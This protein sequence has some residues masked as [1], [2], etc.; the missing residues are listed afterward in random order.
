[1]DVGKRRHTK[2]WSMVIL[3]EE[4]APVVTE[5]TLRATDPLTGGLSAVNAVGTQLRD[6][7]C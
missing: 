2:N 6:L 3:E 7:M 1:M 5:T 4:A